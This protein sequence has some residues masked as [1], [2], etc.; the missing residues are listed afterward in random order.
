MVQIE[1][2][3]KEKSEKSMAEMKC[4][5]R[6]KCYKAGFDNLNRARF[7]GSLIECPRKNP[8]FCEFALPYGYTHYCRCPLLNY[9]AENIR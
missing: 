4:P 3:Q 5:K 2:S 9:A 7:V 1:K 8:R 6:F